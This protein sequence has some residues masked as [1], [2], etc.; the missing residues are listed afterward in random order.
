MG[1]RLYRLGLGHG[2]AWYC[3]YSDTR[4]FMFDSASVNSIS[5]MPAMPRWLKRLDLLSD[6]VPLTSPHPPPPLSDRAFAGVPV[7]EGFAA[8]H[9]SE[10]LGHP[11]GRERLVSA[12]SAWSLHVVSRLALT[13]D[14]PGSGGRRARSALYSRITVEAGTSGGTRAS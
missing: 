9:G 6:S 11:G 12:E 13:W 14:L 5:S 1:F 2:C 3:W 8:E 10:V 7:Q 4:S